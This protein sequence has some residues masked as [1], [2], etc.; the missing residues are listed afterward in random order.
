[1]SDTL[2]PYPSTWPKPT[3]RGF[4]LVCRITEQQKLDLYNRRITTRA[5]ALTLNVREAYLSTIFPGKIPPIKGAKKASR[6]KRVLILARK[7]FR[8]DQ[9]RAVLA[10]K[11]SISAAASIA[12]TSYRNM[13]RVVKTMR[14]SAKERKDAE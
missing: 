6:D 5:L 8:E 12:N 11:M 2:I 10:G 7:T 1:M 13:A 3:D 4:T 9:A 14:D